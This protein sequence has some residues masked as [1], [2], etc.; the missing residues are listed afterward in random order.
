MPLKTETK[1]VFRVISEIDKATKLDNKEKFRKKLQIEIAMDAMKN[2]GKINGRAYGILK[3]HLD[4][5]IPKED[6]FYM[7]E[8]GLLKKDGTRNLKKSSGR[9]TESIEDIL[10]RTY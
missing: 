6:S 4:K 2:H 10:R 7:S 5:K 9:P 1:L 8:T 3:K